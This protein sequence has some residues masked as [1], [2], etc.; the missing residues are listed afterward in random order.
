MGIEPNAVT[1]RDEPHDVECDQCEGGEQEEPAVS[2]NRHRCD[3]ALTFGCLPGQLHN[4][5]SVERESCCD[6]DEWREIGGA[7][8]RA[9][10]GEAAVDLNLPVAGIAEAEALLEGYA[11]GSYKYQPGKA[12][13]Q[14]VSLITALSVDKKSINRIST[15]AKAVND[16]RRLATTPANELYPA[17]FANF[18]D[19]DRVVTNLDIEQ[20][21]LDKFSS[22]GVDVVLA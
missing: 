12:K 7:V 4:S 11:L 15:V 9:L 13:P 10:S 22:A 1:V 19:F 21:Y 6:D 3:S 18:G 5:R 8:A 20:Q 14:P 16:T 2:V 17:K